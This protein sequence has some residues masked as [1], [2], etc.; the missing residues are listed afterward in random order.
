M[1][2]NRKTWDTFE[3]MRQAAHEGDPQAQCYMGVSYQNGQGVTQD[4]HEAVKWFRQ[5][6][7]QNDPRYL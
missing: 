6:A 2:G 5:S 4:Y 7:E 3:E 1:A